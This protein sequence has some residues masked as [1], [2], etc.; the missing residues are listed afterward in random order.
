MAVLEFIQNFSWDDRVY[1][2][3]RPLADLAQAMLSKA[4]VQEDDMKKIQDQLNEKKQE[5]TQ[6][7]KK[8]AASYHTMDLGE[9]IYV[10]ADSAPTAFSQYFS[11]CENSKILTTLVCI[12]PG[13]KQ[14]AF[15]Q[16]YEFWPE[17][18]V[19]PD[20]AC[21]NERTDTE[22]NV[23]IGVTVLSSAADEFVSKSRNLGFTCKVV[24]Y[25][26]EK[27]KEDQVNRGKIENAYNYLQKQLKQRVIF[28]YSTAFTILMHIKVMRVFVDGVLRFGIPPQFFL[29]VTQPYKNRDKQ[30]IEEMIKSFAED[31]IAEMYGSK[32]EVGDGED[33][34]PFVQIQMTSPLFLQ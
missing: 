30:L 6:Y 17:G 28:S 4:K 22:G 23:L 2:R 25:N 20:S 3:N 33:F 27:F 26:L 11:R 13:N 21:I 32:D 9:K 15:L 16:N 1:S 31:Q 18:S 29:A 19:V 7:G 14:Q 8:D 12:V 34:Y 10:T 5:L 24:K